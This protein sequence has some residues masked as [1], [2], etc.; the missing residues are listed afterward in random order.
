MTGRGGHGEG[1]QGGG[2]RAGCWKPKEPVGARREAMGALQFLVVAKIFAP[3]H[4][5]PRSERNQD[6]HFHSPKSVVTYPVQACL[7]VLQD[8][9]P[10]TTTTIILPYRLFTFH[11]T[12]LVT[13][14]S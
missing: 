5:H 4:F 10:L 8:S 12:P 1:R 7:Q 11:P 2:G 6:F 3:A 9:P 13:S 14:A